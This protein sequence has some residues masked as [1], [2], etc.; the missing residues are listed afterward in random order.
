[1]INLAIVSPS[2]IKSIECLSAAH[3]YPQSL[4]RNI[5]SSLAPT[6]LQRRV[7]HGAWIDAAPLA[8]IRDNLIRA[9]G[10][11]DEDGLC[12]DLLGGLFYGSSE[13]EHHGVRVWS[14]PWD[15]SAWELTEGFIR[16]W[17]FLLKGCQ[18]LLD[19]T[20]RWR[21]MRQEEPLVLEIETLTS[22]W[23]LDVL[24]A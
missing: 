9:A 23:N 20:N 7:R 10:S 12:L 17:G 2:A 13:P 4:P 8:T 22:P 16:K 11:Y 14:D 5:P 1:L 18:E 19:A 21:Q 24:S 3:I 15:A 6:L